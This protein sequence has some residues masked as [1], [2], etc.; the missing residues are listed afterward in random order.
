[1]RSLIAHGWDVNYYGSNETCAATIL[2][3]SSN[4]TQT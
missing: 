4:L 3:P 1:M 2:H